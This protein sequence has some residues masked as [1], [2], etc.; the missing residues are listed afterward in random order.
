MR[1]F[2][3]TEEACD[4]V[5]EKQEVLTRVVVVIEK[6]VVLFLLRELPI[7]YICFPHKTSGNHQMKS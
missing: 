7:L 5:I 1:L 3:N 6:H 2:H 4:V